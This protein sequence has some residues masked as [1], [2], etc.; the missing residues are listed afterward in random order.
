MRHDLVIFDCDGVLVDSEPIAQRVLADCLAPYGLML[1]PEECGAL[2][3]G[4][5]MAS[6]AIEANRLGAALPETWVA[7]TYAAMFEALRGKTPP[8]RNVVALLDHLDTCGLPYC[9]ASNGPPA[10]MEITLGQNRLWGRFAGR[11]WSAHEVGTA[12]P[13]PG[14]FLHAAAA[15]GA[16]PDRTVVIED[17]RSGVAAAVAAGMR[18]LGYAEAT[19]GADLRALGAEVFHDMSEVPALLAR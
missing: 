16:A 4:G 5:T 7:E 6:A 11:C 8:V 13:D 18:C 19:G 2:F 15:M 14:L 17:S 12:K 9:V 1:T 10:K 3:V